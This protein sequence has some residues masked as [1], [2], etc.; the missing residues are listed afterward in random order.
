MSVAR[1]L[2][3]AALAAGLV[4]C[5]SLG[6]IWVPRVEGIVVDAE[7]GEPLAGAEVV[8]SYRT[9]RFDSHAEWLVSHVTT[10]SRSATTD[11]D[12]RFAIPA[13]LAIEPV[14][15]GCVTPWYPWLSARHPD[16]GNV[17]WPNNVNYPHENAEKE[18]Q[19]FRAVVIEMEA[20][21]AKRAGRAAG[22][23]PAIDTSG[24]PARSS[25]P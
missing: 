10:D 24:E 17:D 23:P 13:H 8:A 19:F 3:P 7:T 16:Y 20:P 25:R 9:P 12:G 1:R 6:P 15:G 18:R 22:R 11:R 2:L 4:G 21:R 5:F 14:R